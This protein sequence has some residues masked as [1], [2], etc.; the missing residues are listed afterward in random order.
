ML[1]EYYLNDLGGAAEVSQLIGISPSNHGTD[2]D[3]LTYLK[4]IPVLAPLVLGLLNLLGPAFQQQAQG[5]PLID[6]VYG[7]G[8][9]R[10][11]VL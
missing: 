2:L 9:T 8:D 10:P 3:G 11:G 6:E 7:N 1:A 4:G 5:S